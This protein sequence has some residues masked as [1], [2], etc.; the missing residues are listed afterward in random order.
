MKKR[1]TLIFVL[2]LILIVAVPTM[3]LAAE[4]YV[5]KTT[6]IYA[7]GDMYDTNGNYYFININQNKDYADVMLGGSI[8]GVWIDG[9]GTVSGQVLMADGTAS[10][11]VDTYDGYG[12]YVGAIPVNVNF[13]ANSDPTTEKYRM[14][15]KFKDWSYSFKGRAIIT[16]YSITGSINGITVDGYGALANIK[17][18]D[19]TTIKK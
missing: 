6:V 19:V 4:R 14:S 7:D 16:Y 17:Q 2:A 11:I 12:N 18:R 3:A 5:N 8:N 10:F 15:D 13:I 1:L 9:Y